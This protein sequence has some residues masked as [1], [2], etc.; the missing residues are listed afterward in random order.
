MDLALPVDGIEKYKSFS[1]RA[2]IFSE[3]WAMKNLYCPCCDSNRVNQLAGNTPTVDFRCPQCAAGFQL[4][5]S[6]RPFGGR[7]LDGAYSK[8]LYAILHSETPHFL[9]MSYELEN[10]RVQSLICIPDFALTES[11]LE[12][13]KPLSP[14]ARR[15]GYVGCNIL[16]YRIPI[17]A[18]IHLVK[19]AAAQSPTDVRL[20]FRKLKPLSSLKA[21]KRGWTLDILNVVCSLNKSDFTLSE[22]YALEESLAQLHPKNFHIRPKIRQQLQVLRDLGLLIF[23]GDG[24]YRF[25]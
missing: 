6:A 17:D 2:R 13:R 18:R 25:T 3:A 4:K 19:D 12:K 14:T 15:A 11:A 23:L 24:S 10:L 7:L 20:A 22:I 9:L 5:C 16:L 8:M 1:Q 21:E